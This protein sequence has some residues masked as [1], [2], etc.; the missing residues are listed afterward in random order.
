MLRRLARS[1]APYAAALVGSGLGLSAVSAPSV[2]GRVESLEGRLS[3]IEATFSK[4]APKPGR[5]KPAAVVLRTPDEHFENLPLWPYEPKYFTSKLYD[6]DVR[7]AY[8]DLGPRDA[9]ETLILTHGMSAW[10]VS[11]ADN[12]TPFI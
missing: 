12:A 9:E 8:Y 6:M 5:K 2:A 7:I 11:V 3:M 10:C 4:S 1:T